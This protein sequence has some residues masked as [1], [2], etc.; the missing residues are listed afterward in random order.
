VDDYYVRP[1]LKTTKIDE[2]LAYLKDFSSKD[3]ELWVKFTSNAQNLIVRVCKK[4]SGHE[5]ALSPLEKK[6]LDQLMPV[7]ISYLTK[8]YDKLVKLTDDTINFDNLGYKVL[9]HQYD[10]Q[11]NS[12]IEFR[13]A[14]AGSEYSVQLH[15]FFETRV[16]MC[17]FHFVAMSGFGYLYMMLQVY[18]KFASKLML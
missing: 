13:L 4:L 14:S 2:H 7:S 11:K 16:R 15:I 10:W 18:Q 8:Q 5:V 17:L 6:F 3:R 1:F 9:D 12:R